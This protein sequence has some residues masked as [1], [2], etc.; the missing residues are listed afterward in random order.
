MSAFCLSGLGDQTTRLHSDCLAHN[1]LPDF[2]EAP[3][4]DADGKQEPLSRGQEDKIPNAFLSRMEVMAVAAGLEDKSLNLGIPASQS[5]LDPIHCSNLQ[6][7][8]LTADGFR[9]MV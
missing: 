2:L 1:N 7:F 6:H 8:R 3:F 5:L 4:L 9:A